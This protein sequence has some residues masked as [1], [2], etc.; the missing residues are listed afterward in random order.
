MTGLRVLCRGFKQFP[1]G[2]GFATGELRVLS[3]PSAHRL[4]RPEEI[5][6]ASTAAE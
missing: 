3:Q 5:V 2:A 1:Q 4:F 6:N